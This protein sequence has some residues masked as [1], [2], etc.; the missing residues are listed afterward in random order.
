MTHGGRAVLFRAFCIKAL[1]V[2]VTFR[3]ALTAHVQQC[4]HLSALILACV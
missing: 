4:A 1:S 2:A 3:Y